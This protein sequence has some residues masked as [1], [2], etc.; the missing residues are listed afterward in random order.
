[1]SN[2]DYICMT[3]YFCAVLLL[4]NYYAFSFQKKVNDVEFK[5]NKIYE[6]CYQNSIS[7]LSYN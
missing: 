4:I 2:Q 7:K 6:S 1:M 5:V 3:I